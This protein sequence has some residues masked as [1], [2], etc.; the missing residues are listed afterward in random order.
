MPEPAEPTETEPEKTLSH[1]ERINAKIAATTTWV[2]N[3]PPD[4]L[5][6]RNPSASTEDPKSKEVTLNAETGRSTQL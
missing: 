6:E 4:A 2:I 5:G 1:E 3:E